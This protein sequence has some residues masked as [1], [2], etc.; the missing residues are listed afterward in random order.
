MISK[1][2]FFKSIGAIVAAIAVAPE[3]VF[4]HRLSPKN[5]FES[6]FGHRFELSSLAVRENSLYDFLMT[7]EQTEVFVPTLQKKME[8]YGVER[9]LINT[10]SHEQ[11]QRIFSA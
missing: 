7:R 11:L 5:D 2:S 9:S 8:E 3:I 1:R 10:P 6:L 4:S